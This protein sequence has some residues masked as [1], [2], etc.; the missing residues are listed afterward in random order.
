MDGSWSRGRTGRRFP[1]SQ[2]L[3]C[4]AVQILRDHSKLI[5]NG[6]KIVGNVFLPSAFLLR[7]FAAGRVHF[8]QNAGLRMNHM[9][10]NGE[11]PFAHG[12][13]P[14]QLLGHRSRG[15][16]PAQ[17]AFAFENLSQVEG[18]KV[19]VIPESLPSQTWALSP[20]ARIR[21]LCCSHDRAIF[22][23]DNKLAAAAGIH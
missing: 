16:V 6:F 1:Y 22:I 15:K 17:C 21:R 13:E 18:H 2:L 23:L 5:E 14:P 7:L 12:V 20:Q 11:F 10:T 9:A 19:T 4:D 8:T 3:R